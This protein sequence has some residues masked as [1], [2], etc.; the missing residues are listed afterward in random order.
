MRS[1][2]VGNDGADPLLCWCQC[3]IR[4]HDPSGPRGTGDV[5]QLVCTH[6]PTQL[7]KQRPCHN[8]S[9]YRRGF[10]GRPVNRRPWRSRHHRARAWRCL[11]QSYHSVARVRLRVWS[12]RRGDSGRR[13]CRRVGLPR[14]HRWGLLDVA[15]SAETAPRYERRGFAETRYAVRNLKADSNGE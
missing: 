11:S 2:R 13:R 4:Y 14:R 5:A 7:S 15:T 3:C 6:D 1:S 8:I 9:T 12:Q 10:R